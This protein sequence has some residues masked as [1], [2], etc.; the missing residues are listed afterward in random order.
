[1]EVVKIDGSCLKQNILTF[2]YK[3]LV[4]IYSVYGINLWSYTQGGDVD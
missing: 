2:P 4:N 3:T 1:M